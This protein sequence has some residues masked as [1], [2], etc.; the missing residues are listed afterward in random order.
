[1]KKG[2]KIFVICILI[3]LA[4][5]FTSLAIVNYLI[6]PPKVS[7][8]A[9]KYKYNPN[10]LIKLKSITLDSEKVIYEFGA[11][12]K[13][14]KKRY[15][16]TNCKERE[17]LNKSYLELYLSDNYQS[18]KGS[19]YNSDN[20]YIISTLTSNFLIISLDEE[21]E[22]NSVKCF[23]IGQEEDSFDYMYITVNSGYEN[24]GISI[25]YDDILENISTVKYQT[26]DKEKK[27]WSEIRGWSDYYSQEVK[28]NC[29]SIFRHYEKIC[30]N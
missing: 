16:E 23:Y 11:S 28:D 17:A 14:L 20:Y 13:Y 1:M 10:N 12:N 2:I 27:K 21:R 15:V 22:T 4:A 25:I 6:L 7:S 19:E 18:I 5:A 29:I 26:Y 30:L 9:Q 3:F 8:A 24:P